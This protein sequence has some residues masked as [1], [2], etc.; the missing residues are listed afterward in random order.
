MG[1]NDGII[2]KASN[3]GGII[4]DFER[5]FLQASEVELAP[6]PRQNMFVQRFYLYLNVTKPTDLLYLSYSQ[7]SLE[8]K[9][10]RP[11]YLIATIKNMFPKLEVVKYDKNDVKE[12]IINMHSALEYFSNLL[13]IY[14][15]SD[16]KI[17]SNKKKELMTLQSYIK[18]NNHSDYDKLFDAAFYRHIDSKINEDI[19]Q[20]IYGMILSNSVS[21]LEK[22]ASCAYSHFLRYGLQLIER[23]NFELK[24]V[25][26]GN[27][28]HE[29]LEKFA[30]TLE[31]DGISWFDF[32]EK[33]ADELSEFVVDEC[34]NE[35]QNDLLFVDSRTEYAIRRLK[36]II[37]RTIM[38]LQYQL[39][40]G[41]FIPSEFEL[42][43]SDIKSYSEINL[44]DDGSKMKLQGKIDR[45]DLSEDIDNNK[46]YVKV[47]D[48]KSSDHQFDIVSMYY[49][50]QLQ[51]VVY[52]NAATNYVKKVH[53][54][55]DV[56]PAAIL[57]Y[58]VNDPIV[59]SDNSSESD[60]TINS[61][62]Q[63]KLRMQGVVIDDEDAIAKLD[64]TQVSK[65]DV[66]PVAWN[67][68]GSLKKTS[69]V[70]D[71]SMLDNISKFVNVKIRE[72]GREILSG[73][74]NVNP[75]KKD[76]WNSCSYCNYKSICKFD[77]NIEGFKL[78]DLEKKSKDEIIV[79]IGR[80]DE[81]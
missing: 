19:A 11:A 79:E 38:S 28:F 35:Y 2:P 80:I 54:N 59:D 62:I 49:G 39:R 77:K 1:I 47:M 66:I 14:I 52:I 27:L 4:S 50:L 51:L 69:S 74:I 75:C 56:I 40:K 31:K 63:E 10:I 72:M 13:R 76:K 42:S 5:E 6:T 81:D 45:I 64:N 29:S 15:E 24:R 70:M 57:Y 58:H 48:Y 43:F 55:K 46:L 26:I 25:D 22:Y 21:R 18:K 20:L 9:S 34:C 65:S 71:K 12:A 73:N 53:P 33:K 8:G 32:D 36:R 7:I 60:E 23:E 30:K 16:G 3:S 17:D 41:E 61:K 78:R 44:S 37:K 67:K 68:D